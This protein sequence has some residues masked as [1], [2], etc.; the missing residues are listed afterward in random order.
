[1]SILHSGES[2]TVP[3]AAFSTKVL[4]VCPVCRRRPRYDVRVEGGGAWGAAR[5]GR[6]C[7]GLPPSR[8]ASPAFRSARTLGRRVRRQRNARRC[9]ARVRR[10]LYVRH[11]ARAR[12]LASRGC[13]RTFLAPN[14]LICPPFAPAMPLRDVC[15]V[16]VIRGSLRRGTRGRNSRVGMQLTCPPPSVSWF[17]IDLWKEFLQQASDS[18][19]VTILP[20]SFH[21]MG[22]FKCLPSLKAHGMPSVVGRRVGIW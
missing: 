16:K 3:S 11:A 6:A 9:A 7:R 21:H 18:P 14:A 4:F 10:V 12:T 15:L 1:M 17:M 22:R 13:S 5:E 19:C 8:A 20:S 2:E